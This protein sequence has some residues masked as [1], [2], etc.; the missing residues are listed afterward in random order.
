VTGIC[1]ELVEALSTVQRTGD[2]Y[3]SGSLELPA[4]RLEVEGGGQIAFPLL[5]AQGEELIAVAERAPYGRGAATIV[6]TGVRRTWQ[7]G[8]GQVRLGGKHW[9]TTLDR[10][11]AQAAEGLGVSEPVSAE[12]YKLLIYDKGSFFVSH[13]DTEKQSGMFATLVLALPSLSSGGELMVRHKG[14]E[15]RVDLRS[16]EA[17]ELARRRRGAQHD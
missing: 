9:Q 16:E 15:V 12:F 6:D 10:V 11:V 2:F 5:P 13:R 7:I 14:R 17:S 3:T 4:P 1:Q 8:P